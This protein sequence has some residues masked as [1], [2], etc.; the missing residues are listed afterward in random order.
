MCK[1]ILKYCPKALFIEYRSGCN[2]YR[3]LEFEMGTKKLFFVEPPTEA[4]DLLMVN[5]TNCIENCLSVIRLGFK[6]PTV[7]SLDIQL[8]F[9]QLGVCFDF[10]KLLLT[11]ICLEFLRGL[12][13]LGLNVR[14]LTRA[15]VFKVD[16]ILTFF[17][18]I[19]WS[20]VS[21]WSLT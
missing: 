15:L 17:W 2:N 5:L 3:R 10:F 16:W 11:F 19:S 8:C 18:L 21:Y 20:P 12:S 9:V 6:Y 14:A 13:C 7:G 1:F 4:F